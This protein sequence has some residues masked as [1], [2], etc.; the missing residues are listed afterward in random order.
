MA[1]VA[2]GLAE[3]LL[4]SAGGGALQTNGVFSSAGKG[5]KLGAQTVACMRQ[6]QYPA[7]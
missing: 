1:K 4:C 7:G 6:E 2:R 3:Y 5:P